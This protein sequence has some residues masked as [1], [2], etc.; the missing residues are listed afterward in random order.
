[1]E[2]KLFAMMSISVA[3]ASRKYRPIIQNLFRTTKLHQE[4]KR[5]YFH[6][7]WNPR[8]NNV[9]NRGKDSPSVRWISATKHRT[10]Q[11]VPRHFAL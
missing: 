3:V 4:E 11:Y 10:S 8:D 1:M 9:N 5:H 2:L 7:C 6:C